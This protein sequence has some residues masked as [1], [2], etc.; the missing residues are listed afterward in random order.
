M[1]SDALEF[2]A[3]QGFS[4]QWETA[5]SRA[6]GPTKLPGGANLGFVYFSDDYIEHAEEIVSAL[7]EDT[8]IEHWVGSVGIG[9]IGNQGASRND[10]GMSLLIGRFPP[11]SFQVFS[12]RRPLAMPALDSEPYFAVVHG[13][14]N[15]PDMSELVADMSTKVSSGFITGGLSSAS[16]RTVQ[17][18]DE[19][20]SGGISGVA[21]SESVSIATRLTQGCSP[22]PGM[23]TITEAEGNIIGRLDGRSALACYRELAQALGMPDLRQAAGSILVG[24]PAHTHSSDGSDYI[25]R[26]VIGLDPQNGLLAINEPVETG[27]RL[28]FVHRTA[29]AAKHD[30]QRMLD[31]LRASLPSPPKGGLYFSCTGRGDAMFDSD[32][33]EIAMI[34][35]RLGDIPLAGFFAAG[36][37]SHQRLYGYTGVLTLFL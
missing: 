33:A 35:A 9:V 36:E 31:D 18:A 32:S 3:G 25:A 22:L 5:L 26:S 23:H 11:D 19:V 13:D 21:F 28:L 4:A 7:R 14:P 2:V 34:H 29:A 15:T 6:L 16:R 20:L 37:I 24:L 27:Q 12:G 17:I 8:E 1:V 10:P 30:M